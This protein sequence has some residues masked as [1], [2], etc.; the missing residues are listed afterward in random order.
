MVSCPEFKKDQRLRQVLERCIV[1]FVPINFPTRLSCA[2]DRGL[3]KR[4]VVNSDAWVRTVQ[5]QLKSSMLCLYLCSVM[6]T[7][8]TA[9]QVEIVMPEG[10]ATFWQLFSCS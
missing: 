6:D 8:R 5:P 1:L 7:R 3:L 2:W 4:A 9:A 10:S